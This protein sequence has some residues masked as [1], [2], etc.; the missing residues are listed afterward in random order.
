LH[1]SVTATN[2]SA[3]DEI[4]FAFESLTQVHADQRRYGGIN[5]C[6]IRAGVE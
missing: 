2:P 6:L 5:N 1:R 4:D 3:T